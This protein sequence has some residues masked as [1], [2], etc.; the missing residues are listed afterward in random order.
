M[1]SIKRH[2]TGLLLMG[3]LAITPFL[4]TNVGASYQPSEK[5]VAAVSVRFGGGY[6]HRPYYR[7]RNFYRGSPYWRHNYGPRYYRYRHFYGPRYRYNYYNP[8]RYYYDR[9]G[10]IHLQWRSR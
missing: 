9:P 5:E 2:L 6:H 4:M 8:N 1:Y 3:A 10:G 7:H